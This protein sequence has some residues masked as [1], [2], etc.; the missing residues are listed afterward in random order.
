[1][2]RRPP[3]STRT[4][5]LFPYTT[6][7][8]SL[9]EIGE[10]DAGAAGLQTE[11]GEAVEH[12]AGERGEIADAEGEKTDIEDLLDQAVHAV[13]VATPGPSQT[14][15]LDVVVNQGGGEGGDLANVQHEPRGAVAV[16]SVA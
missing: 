15:Q 13:F 1:M 4:D 10:T 2:I 16:E 12:D 7:F 6:L 14:G 11:T 8:R 9:H 5:T 3:R